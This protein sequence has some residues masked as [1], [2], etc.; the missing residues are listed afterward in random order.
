MAEMDCALAEQ[1]AEYLTLQCRHYLDN[2]R[3]LNYFSYWLHGCD[4]VALRNIASAVESL[5]VY[6][7]ET[8]NS[9]ITTKLM[10]YPVLAVDRILA[11]LR[12]KPI[13]IVLMVLFPIGLPVYWIAKKK[14]N[15]IKR[16]IE[17]VCSANNELIVLLQRAQKCE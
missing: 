15:N 6:T 9:L 16:N 14:Y 17:A 5:V 1:K 3:Q 4:M 13:D 10:D 11:P 12:I 2:A 8:T 7:S